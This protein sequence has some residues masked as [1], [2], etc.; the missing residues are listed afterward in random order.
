MTGFLSSE[1]NSWPLV[2]LFLLGAY[3]GLNPGMGWL[4]AVSLGLQERNRGAV[5]RALGPLVL[6]HALSVG[7]VV[8]ALALIEARIP[9]TA[10]RVTAAV[11]LVSFG[12]YRLVRARHP[13]W[14]GMRVNFRDLTVWSFLMSSAHG[15]G[16]MLLP[17]LIGLNGSHAP[18]ATA[19]MAGM[20]HVHHMSSM[21]IV[22]SAAAFNS[23]ASW[24]IPVG[25]HTFGYLLLTT[26]IAVVVYEK[27]GVAILRKSWF[28]LDLVWSVALVGTGILT[29]AM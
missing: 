13:R 7:L 23:P 20:E 2:A 9:H 16:L 12:V 5:V 19:G 26:V 8:A 10:L 1:H 28:N 4:F 17:I 14:V 18:A 25:V 11:I 6:G 15:A 29:L 21:S 27:L 22:P 24:L 3:H